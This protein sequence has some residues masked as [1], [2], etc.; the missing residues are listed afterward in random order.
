MVKV[1]L[2][3]GPSNCGLMSCCCGSLLT[4]CVQRGDDG[5]ETGVCCVGII[6]FLIVVGDA[7]VC[8]NCLVLRHLCIWTLSFCVTEWDG[9]T[10][11]YDGC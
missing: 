11:G 5:R 7:D 1:D 2:V 8:Y 6:F 4:I 10:R 3:R 9:V